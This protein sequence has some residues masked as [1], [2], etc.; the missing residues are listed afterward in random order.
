VNGGID[1]V[2]T[3]YASVDTRVSIA[4]GPAAPAGP[5]RLVPSASITGFVAKVTPA[6]G[7]LDRVVFDVSWIGMAEREDDDQVFLGSLDLVSGTAVVAACRVRITVPA[8][9][10][11]GFLDL[12]TRRS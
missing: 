12:L 8:R 3:E 10:C 1:L 5:A 7:A 9:P 11:V 6:G 2:L 4:V